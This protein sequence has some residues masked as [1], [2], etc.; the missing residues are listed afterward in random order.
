MPQISKKANVTLWTMQSLLALLFL[1]AGGMKLVMPLAAT[2]G[3]IELPGLFVR[4]IGV[5][6]VA[7]GLGL[8]L[9]G[10]LKIRPNLTPL[11][12]VGLV[13]VMTGATV[14]SAV[15]IGLSSAIVPFVVGVL[16]LV[17]F[18]GRGG[19]HLSLAGA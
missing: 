8:I 9:P 15:Y 14:L 16:A 12:A 10:L 11:A 17:I 6:E 19:A 2:Q 5:I 7:G 18:Y 13:A 3:P 4:F 1:F